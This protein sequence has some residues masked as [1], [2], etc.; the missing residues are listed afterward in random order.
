MA[1]EGA[2]EQGGVEEGLQISY[3]LKWCDQCGE[4]TV[5]GLCRKRQ[6]DCKFAK[7]EEVS[8]SEANAQLVESYLRADKLKLAAGEMSAQELRTVRAVLTMLAAKIRRGE[9]E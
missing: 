4:G 3:G 5:Q 9:R 8:I 2:P 6:P 7:P 1:N